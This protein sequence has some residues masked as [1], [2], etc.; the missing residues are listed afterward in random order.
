MSQL[1]PAPVPPSIWHQFRAGLR[2]GV[3]RRVCDGSGMHAYADTGMDTRHGCRG[4]RTAL[5]S[6][7]YLVTSFLTFAPSM[8]IVAS[9]L[10]HTVA[11]GSS[12]HT[13]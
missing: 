1:S 10:L 13:I 2:E 6:L 5:P 12:Q 3:P 7:L 8:Y 4:R 11:K 9:S